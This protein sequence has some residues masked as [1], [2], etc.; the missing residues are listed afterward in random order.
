MQK[1]KIFRKVFIL[2]FFLAV[3]LLSFGVYHLTTADEFEEEEYGECE[4]DDCVWEI[5][6]DAV[7]EKGVT[8]LNKS[9]WIYEGATLTIKPGAKIEFVDNCWG[10]S[11][12]IFVLGGRIVANGTKENPI[13]ISRQGYNHLNTL[14]YFANDIYDED[15][16]VSTPESMFSYVKISGGGTSP[17]DGGGCVDGICPAFQNIFRSFVNTAYADDYGDSALNFKGGKLRLE[18]CQFSDNYGLDVKVDLRVENENQDDSLKIIN[19][20]FEN[21]I[22]NIAVVSDIHGSQINSNPNLLDML[23]LQ[24]NWYGS[25]SG[26]K[27]SLYDD[28]EGEFLVGASAVGG[29]SSTRWALFPDGNANVLFLPGVKASYLYKNGFLGEDQLWPPNYF[30]DDVSEL[31][32]DENG[33]SLEDVYTKDIIEQLPFTG[34]NIYKSFA[35]KLA[36]LKE[37]RDINDYNL[38]AYDWRKNVEDIEVI[39]EIEKLVVTSQNKKVTIVAHS[40]GGLLAKDVMRKLEE[41]GRTDIIDK[42]IFVG[43]P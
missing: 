18:N 37:N 3:I 32:L 21:N 27:L 11:T 43:T 4:A 29:F 39:E 19:S 40:N 14:L 36:E 10:E 17:Y 28:R 31:A 15:G 22:N 26:P 23:V 7:L 1:N 2:V 38:F 35:E 34:K 16:R 6:D 12:Q 30:G 8:V 41:M 42:I 13:Y 9:V 25:P 5:R 33:E 20:N 24:N